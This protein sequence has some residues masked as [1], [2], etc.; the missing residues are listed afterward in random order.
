MLCAYSRG[1][2]SARKIEPACQENLVFLVLACG[3]V[4]DHRPIATFVSSMQ[5]EMLSILRD[6]LRVCAEQT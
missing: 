4:L 3:A 2:L 1:I 6:S 5:A